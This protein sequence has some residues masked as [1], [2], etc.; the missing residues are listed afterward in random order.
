MISVYFL[1]PPI[2]W[3]HMRFRLLWLRNR[4]VGS[5]SSSWVTTSYGA[6]IIALAGEWCT[7]MSRF[8]R[9]ETSGWNR[10]DR[11]YYFTSSKIYLVGL[12]FMKLSFVDKNLKFPPKNSDIFSQCCVRMFTQIFEPNRVWKTKSGFWDYLTDFEI[13]YQSILVPT[14]LHRWK[15]AETPIIF[16]R[17]AIE[18]PS[19]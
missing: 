13:T 1:S 16:I 12:V 3:R 15:N 17:T 2:L 18:F 14:F 11:E 19:L 7:S 8:S 9:E 4:K 10:L 6:K 5:K